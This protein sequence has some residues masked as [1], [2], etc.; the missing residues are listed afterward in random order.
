[1]P[2]LPIAGGAAA[3]AAVGGL[4]WLFL[5]TPAPRLT[6]VTPPRVEAG[7]PVT[8]AGQGFVAEPGGNTV[9][10]GSQPGAVTAA[11][12]TELKA[13]VPASL[14]A[15]DV[16]L[17][18]ETKGGRSAHLVL[19]VFR[20]AKVTAL[21]PDVAESGAT[22]LIRGEELSGQPL[23]VQI[24][25]APARVVEARPDAIHAVVPALGLPEGQ[26]AP[27]VVQ[28]GTVATKAVDL[29]IGRLPL[30]MEVAPKGGSLGERVVIKGRGFASD[31]AGN[32]VTFGG[33]P[34]LVL[35]ASATELAVVVPAPTGGDV[36]PDVPVVVTAGGRAST[37]P[38][39]FV[40][41]RGSA[42]SFVPRFY[43]APVTEYPGE[44]LVFVATELAPVLL[45]GGKADSPTTAERAVRVA[46]ALNTL[47]DGAA[48]RPTAFELRERPEASV[49]VVGSVSPFLVP[50]PEDAAAYS[51]P[52]EGGRGP[53]RRVTTP[54]LA[55]HWAAI[56]QDYF[57]LFLYRQRPLQMLA[58]SPRGKVLGEIYA[59]AARRA[60]G[61][62]GVSS[63]IVLPT[64]ASMATALRQMALVVSSEGAR[65]AVAVEG[66]WEGR[67]ED[68]DSGNRRFQVRLR[69]DGGRLVGALTM[70]AGAIELT[71]PLRDLGFDHGDVRFTAE[72]QGTAFHF[73][74]TLE[75]NTVSGT[76]ERKGKSPVP[77]TLQYQE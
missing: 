43:A 3:L 28:V 15:G 64:P 29:L 14:A 33:Q 60:P 45:L 61:G 63:S 44:G 51:K 58:L 26:K 7:Q 8:L 50:T 36:Q 25:G 11:K 42:S 68:P 53:G 10:F 31:P 23:A 56:L 66:R 12:K 47:I 16:S 76:I 1:L 32:T 39:S 75:G 19:K 35:T 55:R 27:V 62:M 69:A 18:V 17:V 72:L 71:S 4:G 67:I 38:A 6:S 54:A 57:G 40:I 49:G 74:G 73:R 41:G 65:A 2:I 21:E 59:D 46:A 70:W 37:S 20:S 13:V 34:A 9:L 30:V 5:R 22:I 24:G 52:W 77:F 48:R